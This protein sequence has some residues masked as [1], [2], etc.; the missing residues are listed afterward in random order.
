MIFFLAKFS[1][2]GAQQ[3][4]W[5]S[6]SAEEDF[7]YGLTV[8]HGNV[9]IVGMAEGALEGNSHLGEGDL[10]LAKYNLSE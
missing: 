5:E 8:D 7:A 3:W 10:F 6:G 2:S 1:S 9:Y 4:I